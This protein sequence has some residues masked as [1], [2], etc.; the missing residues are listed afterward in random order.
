MSDWIRGE[1]ARDLLRRLNEIT[2]HD[3]DD[4]CDG[5]HCHS[6]GVDHRGE[7]WDWCFECGHAYRKSQDLVKAY[8]RGARRLGWRF[9]LR[10]RLTPA[11]RLK[12]SFC[13]LCLHDF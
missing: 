9:W 5:D 8:R 11:R 6:C 3:P 1:S 13:P 4:D 12:I 2:V 10:V 7:A